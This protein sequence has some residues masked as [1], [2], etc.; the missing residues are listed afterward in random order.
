[1]TKREGITFRNDSGCTS[2]LMVPKAILVNTNPNLERIMLICHIS[3]DPTIILG[4]TTIKS[5]TL[6]AVLVK[7]IFLISLRSEI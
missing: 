7:N 3:I 6:L 1:M 4:K 5:L 2:Y